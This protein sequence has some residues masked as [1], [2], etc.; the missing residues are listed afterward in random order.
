MTVEQMKKNIMAIIGLVN[1]VLAALAGL[2]TIYMKHEIVLNIAPIIMNITFVIFLIVLIYY[3]FG[4]LIGFREYKNEKNYNDR[5][6]QV[7]T[8]MKQQYELF[9]NNMELMEDSL[10]EKI[11]CPAHKTI[12]EYTSTDVTQITNQLLDRHPTAKIRIICFGRNGYGDVIEHVKEK[13]LK[14]QVEII[15]YYPYG[16]ECICRPTD[17]QDILHHIR[18]M[19]ESETPVKVYAT[20]IPPS[21][22]ACVISENG[23]AIWGAIQSYR[24]EKR[25]D[26]EISLVKPKE[27]LIPVCGEYTANKDFNGLVR[28]FEEE[29]QYLKTDYYDTKI[30]K[31]EVK[32]TLHKKGKRGR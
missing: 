9:N 8:E 29:F 28:C 6:I 20:N 11:V 17:T 27:S 7:V 16:K 19:L 30:L 25:N 23:K 4:A 31:N 1:F 21:I 22:R 5:L 10:S 32:F 2:C 24:F 14:V 26:G 13:K 3:V 18:K 15:V 12:F